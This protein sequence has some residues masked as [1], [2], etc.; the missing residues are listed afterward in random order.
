MRAPA[1]PR[2]RSPE[3]SLDVGRVSRSRS[4]ALRLPDGVQDREK[5]TAA[6]AESGCRPTNSPPCQSV[7]VLAWSTFAST[8]PTVGL[9]VGLDRRAGDAVLAPR[10][11]GPNLPLRTNLGGGEA[12]PSGACDLRGR[13][14]RQAARARQARLARRLGG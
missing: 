3:Q 12:R 9:D 8:T 14:R 6:A 13:Q 1:P 4:T 10:A 2:P 7:S 11:R 5:A